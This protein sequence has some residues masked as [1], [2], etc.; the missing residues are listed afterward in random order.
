MAD[1]D[2]KVKNGL[3][4]GT[5]LSLEEGGTGQT[6]A[7]NAIN[8]LLPVQ[9]LNSGKYL[10]TDGTN[11]SWG[12]VSV[13]QEIYYTENAPSSPSVGTIWVESDSS[14]SSFDPNLIRRH[15]FTATAGQTNFVASIAFVDGFEQVYFNGLLL[16]KTVDYTTSGN[17][18]V[19]LASAAAAGDIVEIVAITNLSS[20]NTYTQGEI[21][22]TYATIIEEN[23]KEIA[24]IM[25]AY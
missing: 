1:K 7:N 25:G 23:N 15:T 22:S 11:T 24:S 6:S 14:I 16:L 2:F 18:T 20:V 21:N 5:P 12:T 3:D 4:L 17:T 10:T 19:T 8:A 9:S 13:P